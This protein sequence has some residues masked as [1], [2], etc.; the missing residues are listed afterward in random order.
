[1]L[2]L[3]VL[4]VGVLLVVSGLVILLC[5]VGGAGW[6][7]LVMGIVVLLGTVFERWRYRTV[8]DAAPVQSQRTG[9]SF[10]D[11]ATGEPIQ[12]YFD[13]RTGER[14]YVSDKDIPRPQ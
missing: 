14:R 2:R 9:E 3:L 7:V 10:L 6:P 11:P 1:M 13:P 12:V 5:T 8:E 4:A